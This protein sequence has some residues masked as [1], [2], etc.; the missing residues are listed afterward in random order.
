MSAEKQDPGFD[1]NNSD[2]ELVLE[3]W[4][5]VDINK[6]IEEADTGKMLTLE[7]LEAEIDSWD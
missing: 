1:N 6:A 2:D 4:M 7:E 5:I 3:P